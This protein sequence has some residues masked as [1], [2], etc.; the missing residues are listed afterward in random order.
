MKTLLTDQAIFALSFISN[1]NF[2]LDEPLGDAREPKD[3]TLW[4]NAQTRVKSGLDAINKNLTKDGHASL[5]W[6]PY[7]AT[8]PSKDPKAEGIYVTDNAM[9]VASLPD[10]GDANKQLLVVALAGTSS[11]SYVAAMDE[12]FG[13]NMVPL[14]VPSGVSTDALVYEGGNTVLQKMIGWI[15]QT[16]KEPDYQGFLDNL[17]YQVNQLL[18]AQH[19]VEVVVTGHSLGGGLA[20]LLAAYLGSDSSIVQSEQVTVSCYTYAGPTAG[21]ENFRTFL[22]QNV[23]YNAIVNPLDLVPMAWAPKSLLQIP[24]LYS[25]QEVCGKDMGTDYIVQGAISWAKSLIA[26]NSNDFVQASNPTLLQAEGLKFS[27]LDCAKLEA[28]A[29]AI[30]DLPKFAKLK[31]NMQTIW[32]KTTHTDKPIDVATIR[33][34]LEFG[35]EGGHQHVR[36]YIDQ[37]IDA[38]EFKELNKFLTHFMSAGK[39]DKKAEHYDS[40]FILNTILTEAAN[41]LSK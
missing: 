9:Y 5:T 25:G 23:K 6:G 4:T 16:Q 12:D 24:S 18:D 33:H 37:I 35:E 2:G 38:S 15:D 13:V 7:I 32:Q 36:V 14:S 22:T 8:S 27:M 41:Y 40:G 19:S 26:G 21:D 17:S 10:P 31:A 3:K 1:A 39:G 11:T 30:H 29:I 34:F 28:T 20:P